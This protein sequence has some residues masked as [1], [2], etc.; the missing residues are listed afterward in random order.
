[1]DLSLDDFVFASKYFS[2]VLPQRTCSCCCRI[3]KYLVKCWWTPDFSDFHPTRSHRMCKLLF[4]KKSVTSNPNLE[5]THSNRWQ[6]VDNFKRY[7][8]FLTEF[9]WSWWRNKNYEKIIRKQQKENEWRKTERVCG[10]QISDMGV[11]W[12][13]AVIVSGCVAY[14]RVRWCV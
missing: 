10:N 13:H 2:C 12:E 4:F 9:L 8:N 3:R 7:E 6:N 14:V 1:M 5:V 11:L